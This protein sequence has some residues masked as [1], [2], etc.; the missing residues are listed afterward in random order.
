MKTNGLYE[1]FDSGKT[2]SVVEGID[3][4][5]DIWFVKFHPTLKRVY[6]STSGKFSTESLKK[7]PPDKIMYL[8]NQMII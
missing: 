2:W 8:Y 3:A 6:I 1:S 5:C 4:T 7:K